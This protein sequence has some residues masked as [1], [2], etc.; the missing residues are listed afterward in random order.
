M[1]RRASPTWRCAPG[2]PLGQ[3]SLNAFVNVGACVVRALRLDGA[4]SVER[5]AM[6]EDL[7][8]IAGRRQPETL[9]AMG[10]GVTNATGMSYSM[11]K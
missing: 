1:K 4:V 9:V 11:A 2:L 10:G 7:S 3:G 8:G 5:V 6:E